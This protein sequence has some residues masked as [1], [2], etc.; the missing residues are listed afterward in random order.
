MVS[1]Y[2]G[3][4]ETFL[5]DFFETESGADCFKWIQDQAEKLEKGVDLP[6]PNWVSPSDNDYACARIFRAVVCLWADL[7]TYDREEKERRFVTAVQM[8]ATTYPEYA[9]GRRCLCQLMIVFEKPSL[10][11]LNRAYLTAMDTQLKDLLRGL[12]PLPPPPSPP[13]PPTPTSRVILLPPAR[14][15]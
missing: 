9:T 1:M 11:V 6:E 7:C 4:V 5:P 14:E 13:P 8:D 15:M 3:I 10:E 2:R 12:L